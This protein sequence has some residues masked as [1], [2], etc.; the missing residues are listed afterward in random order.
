MRM[1][2]PNATRGEPE[3]GPPSRK[4]RHAQG[5][6]KHPHPGLDAWE[7]D[8]QE[9]LRAYEQA[10]LILFVHNLVQGDLQK[11]EVDFLH[12]HEKAAKLAGDLQR[13]KA[14]LTTVAP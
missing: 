12:S 1:S 2:T 13:F 9:A 7:E 3:P 8:T 5:R 11:Q 6:Q 10:D 14:E 4:C